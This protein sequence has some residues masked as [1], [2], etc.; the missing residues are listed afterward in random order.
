VSAHITDALRRVG[1]HIGYDIVPSARQRGH[2]TAMV[3]AALPIAARMGIDPALVTCDIDNVASRKVIEGNGGRLWQAGD[4]K[5]RFW[6]PTSRPV[7]PTD[8]VRLA[9]VDAHTP[10]EP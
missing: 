6:L 2:A 8:D 1:G 7:R 4:G 9:S 10:V 5:L 3:R